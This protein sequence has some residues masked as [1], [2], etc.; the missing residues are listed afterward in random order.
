MKIERFTKSQ[1][2]VWLALAA[3]GASI[4]NGAGAIIPANRRIDWIPGVTV[5]VPGGIP[6]R[7]TIFRTLGP[8]ATAADINAAISQC[9]SGQVVKLNPG[10]YN[11]S[12]TIHFGFA[13]G[14][15]L[16]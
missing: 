4:H 11:I 13:K 5:G 8:T 15:T 12:S 16:R 9:P 7:T 2:I 1:L 3:L 10:T 6:N 14:V